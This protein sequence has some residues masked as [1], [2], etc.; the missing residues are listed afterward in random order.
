MTGSR[1]VS[2]NVGLPGDVAWQG[3]TVHTGAWK[4]PV[5]GPAMVRRLNIDGD[6]QGDLD[7]HGGENRAVL[8]YQLGSYARWRK[9]LG[10]PELGSGMFGE[11]LTIEG[12]ADDEV[13]IG[14]RL[15]IGQAEF[16]VT[17]PRVTCFRVGMRLNEPRL[18]AMMVAHHRPGFYLRVLQ[19][20]QVHPG[21][22]ITLLERGRHALSV[23]EADALLYLPERPVDRLRV[24][25]DI[26]AL[27]PGW[28]TSFHDLLEKSAT[29]PSAG[30]TTQNPVVEV[31]EPQGVPA[32]A[33]FRPLTVTDIVP[34]AKHIMSLHLAA[35][36]GTSLPGWVA[37][38]HVAVRVPGPAGEPVVRNYSLSSAPGQ[39]RYRISVKLE[40]G[41]HVSSHLHRRIRPGSALDVAAPR[42]EFILDESLKAVV[43]LSAG[44]GAT[45]VL[46]M[47][48]Q[49]AATG[50]SRRI[51]WVH[52]ARSPQTT[53]FTAEVERLV[54]SLSNITAR[55]H[56]SAAKSAPAGQR[57]GRLG[58][59]QLKELGVP[60]D[61]IAYLCGPPSFMSSM[62][63]ALYEAGLTAGNVRSER[64][65]ARSPI[66]PGIIGQ[67]QVRPHPPT[68]APGS[69]PQVT[70]AR[71]ALTVK[72]SA[73][74]GSILELAE[75]CDVPT[76]W[77]CRTGVCHT[78]ITE[79]LSG[80]TRYTE[81]PLD[82][83]PPGQTLIC[84]SAP[85]A[86]LTVDL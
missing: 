24:A 46:A 37:G 83:P 34:E 57:Q 55:T 20:G 49:L 16:E 66:N 40:P 25:V 12:M 11:N 15:R 48:H 72:W 82:P 41:G 21:D 32:W 45:P 80:T 42:G 61:A 70:F 17:Q 22:D 58:V 65:G 62:E 71:S 47:L 19:E 86:N 2:V 30:S 28:R 64:F 26:P 10:R 53:P 63:S 52:A 4:A 68:T 60:A 39:A 77:S 3:R 33:G 44:I 6:G 18:A 69:G 54:S 31:I 43:L 36:D 50:S 27:S 51:W 76:Q 7:G 81:P 23:A 79:V 14:D 85:T 35:P 75:A 5:S 84:T 74:F 13:C 73:E 78:C 1:L 29:A 38:Q 9:V 67:P 56:Y 8:V 59:G